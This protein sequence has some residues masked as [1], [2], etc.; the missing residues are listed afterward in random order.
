VR[1]GIERI[2]YDAEAVA[3]RMREIRLPGGL[4]DDLPRA[5]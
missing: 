2:A 5:A 1:V 4:A 3:A